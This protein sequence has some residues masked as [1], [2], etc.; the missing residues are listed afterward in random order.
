MILHGLMLM[1]KSISIFI[2]G[3]SILYI[4]LKIIST[5]NIC[6]S[7]KA[8]QM[9]MQ[10]QTEPK[11]IQVE[12]VSKDLRVKAENM[13]NLVDIYSRRMYHMQCEIDAI[14]EQI[15]TERSCSIT[16]SEEHIEELIVRS[17]KIDEDKY[18]LES[19][20][21]KLNEELDKIA[22]TELERQSM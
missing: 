20:V 16:C 4:I 18:K 8:E 15:R 13:I 14:E 6:K 21:I 10:I 9:Q 22:R 12:I 1:L 7:I 17:L 2:V 3:F 19:K 11:M 5:I